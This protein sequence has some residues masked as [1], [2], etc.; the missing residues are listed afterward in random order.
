MTGFFMKFDVAFD[1]E[2]ID[3][4]L[5]REEIGSASHRIVRARRE[6]PDG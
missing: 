3:K 6:Y 2:P 5:S 4:Y 1:L